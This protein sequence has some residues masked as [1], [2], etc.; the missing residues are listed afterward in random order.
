MSKKKTMKRL[1]DLDAVEVSFVPAGINGRKFLVTKSAEG[2]L[3]EEEIIKELLNSDLEDEAAI[4]EKIL[5]MLPEEIKKDD[6]TVKQV[7]GGMKAAV[8]L[9]KGI[10]KRLPEADR[11][12]VLGAM[13]EMAGLGNVKKEDPTPEKTKEQIAKEAA[14]AEAEKKAKADKEKI[15]KEDKLDP[16]IQAKL[17]LVLKSNEKLG[18]ENKGLKEDIKKERDL[19][20]IKEFQDKAEKEFSHV[21][22]STQVGAVLKSAKD[23]MSDDEYKELEKVMKSTQTKLEAGNIFSELGSSQGTSTDLESKIQVKK[24]AIMKEDKDMT[25]EMAEA[26]V[27]EQ[28]P[29]LYNEY[30]DQN[31]AQGGR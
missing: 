13:H 20:V 16:A 22:S 12:K 10:A 14:D 21:G 9:L 26:K 3:M 7:Q 11:D 27:F 19:R 24:E 17:D 25:K 31:P 8:K 6:K 1:F 18:D 15:A 4:D 29:E 23:N 2:E 28:N 5:K 30:L